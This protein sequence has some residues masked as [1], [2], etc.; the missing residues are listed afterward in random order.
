MGSNITQTTRQDLPS[1]ALGYGQSGLTSFVRTFFPRATF[2]D[3]GEIIDIGDPG[4]YDEIGGVY[5]P[6]LDDFT[7]LEKSGQKHAI[8]QVL[9]GANLRNQ[10]DRWMLDQMNGQGDDLA[11]LTQTYNMGG[12]LAGASR[13]G[14]LDALQGNSQKYASQRLLDDM[15]GNTS[16]SAED[17]LYGMLG[18]EGD[19]TRDAAFDTIGGGLAGNARRSSADTINGRYLSPDS[20]PWFRS[21]VDEGTK[22]I[23]DAYKYATMPELMGNAART[24]SFGGSAHQQTAGMKQFELGRNLSDF[25][26][27]MYSGNYQQERQNQLA[28]TNAER[29]YTQ[30]Q[31]EAERGRGYTAAENALSRAQQAALDERGGWR[32]LLD[33]QNNRMM[34]SSEGEL[35]RGIQ[36]MSLFPELM[37]GRYEEADVL[38]RLG[39]EDRQ[40]GEAQKE[41]DYQNRLTDF[42]WPFNL[43]NIL[44]S[45]IASM[46]GGGGVTTQT[47]PN[48]NAISP[49]AGALGGGLA[50]VGLLSSMFGP[51]QKGGTTQTD[52]ES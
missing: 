2:N 7:E 1:W 41:V 50:G 35:G 37:R 20:N 36:S 46:T 12:P 34:S 47:S 4:H 22:A 21:T 49:V 45:T 31:L 48:P 5:R 25:V 6:M 9:G 16:K 10:A 40:L 32:S 38:R 51:Q 33:A 29:G 8:N 11:R 3:K 43:Y 52:T 24:G 23:A 27:K 17:R 13:V 19:Y 14:L 42:Q 26:N 39:A 44:G 30:S 15:Y 18:S 28:A